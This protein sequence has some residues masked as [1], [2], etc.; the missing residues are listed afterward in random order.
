ML[1]VSTLRDFAQLLGARRSSYRRMW[2]S[3]KPIRML[4]LMALVLQEWIAMTFHTSVRALKR[5]QLLSYFSTLISRHNG[6]RLDEN[7]P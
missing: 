7:P 1:H 6:P 5:I 2:T 3:S 4:T